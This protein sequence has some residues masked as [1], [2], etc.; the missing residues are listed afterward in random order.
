MHVLVKE[1][2]NIIITHYPG[3][4]NFSMAR[5]QLREILEEIR[6]IDTGQSIILAKVKDPYEAV[7][8]IR[9][10]GLRETPI[11]RV[12]PVDRVTDIYV[13]R[14]AEAVRELLLGKSKPEESFKIKIDGHLYAL[15]EDV[16]ERLHKDEAIK[17]IAEGIDRPVDLRNPD[18]LVYVK[19]VRLY[20]VTELASVTVC[21]P[22]DILSFAPRES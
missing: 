1:P 5:E 17:I 20:R 4:D 11:L 19:A 9:D 13:D 15:R 14:V 2:F 6:I 8:I 10:S 22:P 21:R 7:K 16:S 12:I 3:Y 18:W